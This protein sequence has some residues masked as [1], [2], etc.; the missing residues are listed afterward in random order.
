MIFQ[1]LMYE[2]FHLEYSGWVLLQE[3]HIYYFG[4]NHMSQKSLTRK[5]FPRPHFFP[6]LIN[7]LK[8][9]TEKN[10]PPRKIIDQRPYFFNYTLKK[11]VVVCLNQ[12][13][14]R[15]PGDYGPKKFQE[16]GPKFQ[17]ISRSFPGCRHP[18]LGGDAVER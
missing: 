2:V 13:S 7:N 11:F 17:E 3:N 9:L 1:K 15:F 8:Q 14:R 10:C 16:H 4:L 12:N 18:V 6:D 5:M